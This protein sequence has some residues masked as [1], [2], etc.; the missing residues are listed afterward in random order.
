MFGYA[1]TD[2]PTLMPL[3]IDIAHR[4][5]EELS[6]VRKDGDV[7]FLLPDGKTQVTIEYDG[8]R[9]VRVD[10]VVVSTQH[11]EAVS[12]ASDRRGGAGPGD[13]PGAGALRDRLG[14]G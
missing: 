8:D 6:K 9:A 11:V 3:P 14:A 4:L 10:T 5:S 7:D 12:H 1:C 2:T 13:R